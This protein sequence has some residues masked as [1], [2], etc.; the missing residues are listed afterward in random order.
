MMVSMIELLQAVLNT[1]EISGSVVGEAVVGNSTVY[2]VLRHPENGG[3]SLSKCANEIALH[4]G[5]ESIKIEKLP[6]HNAYGIV[7]PYRCTESVD[8]A[9]IIESPELKGAKS[10]L[11]F[12]LGKDAFSN[13]IIGDLS[14]MPHLLVGGGADF[15]KS[16]FL[17]QIILSL[18][19]KCTPDEVSLILISPNSNKMLSYNGVPHLAHPAISDPRDALRALGFLNK[20]IAERFNSFDVLAKF[21]SGAIKNDRSMRSRYNS[22]DVKNISDYNAVAYGDDR[23]R[24]PYVVVVIDELSELNGVL[25]SKAEN[26]ILKLGTKARAAG[27]HL[28]L[29][30]SEIDNTTITDAIKTVCPSRVAFKVSDA[31]S[32]RVILDRSGAENLLGGGDMLYQHGFSIRP[33]RIQGAYISGE[34]VVRSVKSAISSHLSSDDRLGMSG[35]MSEVNNSG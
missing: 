33:K 26:P 4:L 19:H 9:D 3:T 17:D 30:T 34:A 20:L 10:C 18:L 28:V 27:I 32:S 2:R 7:T 13:T 1:Y 8:A 6:E 23:A 15:G 29:A 12:V 14:L 35:F 21:L 11:S 24:M 25:G 22:G 31:N 16:V 5:V